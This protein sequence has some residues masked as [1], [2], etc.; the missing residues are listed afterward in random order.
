MLNRELWVGW[1]TGSDDICDDIDD[2]MYATRAPHC[3]EPVYMGE[4]PT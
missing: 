3:N 1:T 4:P 2:V